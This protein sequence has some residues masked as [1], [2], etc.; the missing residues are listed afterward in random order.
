[1]SL[2]LCCEFIVD[3]VKKSGKVEEVNIFKEKG[4]QFNQ[5]KL[6]K[7]SDKQILDLYISNIKS[8]HQAVAKY[9]IP[10]GIRSLRISSDILPLSDCNTHLLNDVE[11]KKSIA[12]LGKL[13]LDTAMRITS[14]PSQFVVLSSKNPNVIVNSINILQQH[15][16]LFDMMNLPLTPYY[17]INI[18]GGAKGESNTLISSILS[19]PDNIRNRLTLENDERSYSTTELYKIFQKTNIPVVFDSHHASFNS[20][21]IES[22]FNLALS[23][24]GNVKPLTHLSNTRPDVLPTASF[25]DRRAHSEYVHYIPEWQRV[26]HQQ[27]SIDIDF[28][29]KAKNKAI[30]AA[31]SNFDISL[32]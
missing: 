12:S 9:V 17:A 6:G 3:E 1:M 13:C 28:E 20:D 4:L 21:N 22:D 25:N 31:L 29:F 26:A 2:G 30:F 16:I 19:L 18:H 10:S 8:L 11:L 24:W 15:A 23:T 7:Y 5:F 32:T 27:G 14:H